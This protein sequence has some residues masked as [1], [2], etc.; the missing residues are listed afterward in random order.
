M[1]DSSRPELLDPPR[2]ILLALDASVSDGHEA[3]LSRLCSAL[4]R[5]TRIPSHLR[6]VGLAPADVVIVACRG[7]R[8]SDLAAIDS[9]REASPA[10]EIVCVC[11]KVA[12]DTAVE[13][14]RR[15]VFAIVPSASGPDELRRAIEAAAIR[16]RRGELRLRALRVTG[17]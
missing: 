14:L 13:I 16:R 11:S 5:W 15:G 6:L 10:I 4:T 17:R 3:E 7:D 12:V 2:A 8:D 9:L 1:G